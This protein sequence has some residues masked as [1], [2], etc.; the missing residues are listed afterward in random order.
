MHQKIV[1]I[2]QKKIVQISRK[3]A[4]KN[5]ILFVN[6]KFNVVVLLKLIQKNSLNEQKNSSNNKKKL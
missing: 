2:S 3:T 5:F 6:H 1:K 4:T